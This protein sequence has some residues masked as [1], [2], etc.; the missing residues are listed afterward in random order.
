MAGTS[1]GVAD[2]AR[3]TARSRRTRERTRSS[4]RLRQ[5]M[6]SQAA[7]RAALFAESRGF[8][9]RLLK[10]IEDDLVRVGAFPG[11]PERDP[12]ERAPRTD[13]RASRQRLLVSLR[14]PFQ[15]A[16]VGLVGGR[17]RGNG[18]RDR[19][20][21]RDPGGLPRIV[22]GETGPV[23]PRGSCSPCGFTGPCCLRRRRTRGD[24]AS[25]APSLHQVHLVRVALR[26]GLPF[27]SRMPSHRA[28]GRELGG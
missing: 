1:S 24:G 22:P 17:H 28:G 2:S 18:H 10:G 21:A 27:H 14:H 11:D 9:P 4:A 26:R 7:D 23:H 8:A 19:G 25:A 12:V 13:R 20:R 3:V 16:P 5:I 15:E 6:V